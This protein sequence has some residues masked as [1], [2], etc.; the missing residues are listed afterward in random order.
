MFLCYLFNLGSL[1]K[2]KKVFINSLVI[3]T[4][5]L[6]KTP[7]LDQKLLKHS[8]IKLIEY[9]DGFRINYQLTN[10]NEYRQYYSQA[11]DYTTTLIS[12]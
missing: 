1:V 11:P 6:I 2:L 9:H 8:L 4:S 5:I 12:I 3:G 7:V 10:Q